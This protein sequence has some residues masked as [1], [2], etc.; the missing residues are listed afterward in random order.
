VQL[1][2]AAAAL[3]VRLFSCEDCTAPFKKWLV[4]THSSYCCRQAAKC[5]GQPASPTL[6]C[7]G[8]SAPARQAGAALKLGLQCLTFMPK[9]I[10][11]SSGG[12]F[13]CTA[14]TLH[15]LLADDVHTHTRLSNQCF[16][17]CAVMLKNTPKI[18]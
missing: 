10:G 16:S 8:T 5:V 17:S 18:V 15:A 3:L 2:A 6:I 13:G 9:N 12:H 1:A 4:F 11:A 7:A 14:T